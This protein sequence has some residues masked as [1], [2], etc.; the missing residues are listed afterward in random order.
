MADGCLYSGL[1][2]GSV[3]AGVVGQAMP[4]Y[5]LF[6]SAVN[7]AAMFEAGGSR[8]KTTY[9]FDSVNAG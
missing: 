4:R 1:H 5:C 7:T 3:V 9:V 2:T 8:E 6:G